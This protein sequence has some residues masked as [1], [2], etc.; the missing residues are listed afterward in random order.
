[1]RFSFFHPFLARFLLILAVLFVSVLPGCGKK[2]KD[3]PIRFDPNIS[4]N[5]VPV[6]EFWPR[7]DK[8]FPKSELDRAVREQALEK[9]GRPDYLRQVYTVDRRVIRPKD[10]LEG[11]HLPGKKATPTLE[12]LYIDEKLALEFD[13]PRMVEHELDDQL[14]IAAIYGDANIVRN[15]PQADGRVFQIH[16]YYNHAKEF[17]FYGTTLVKEKTLTSTLPGS[18]RIKE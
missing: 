10:I 15:H 7:E 6:P 4:V 14:R 12:W 5:V 9:Y 11:I 2:P 16:T 8:D 3:Q 17:T 1:M 13:G 18:E